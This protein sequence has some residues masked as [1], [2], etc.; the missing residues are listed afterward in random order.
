LKD[1]HSEKW[2]AVGATLLAFACGGSGGGGTGPCTPG[3]AT[4]LVK[5]GSDP[6]W[7]LNNPLPNPLGVT[8]KDANNCAVPGIVVNWSITTGGGGLG[9]TQSTTNSSG[10]ATIAD[11]VGSTSPQVVHAGSTG[12][13]SADFQVTA[14]APPT[15][16]G[17]AI[18]DFSFSPQAVVIKSGGT[19]TWTWGGAAPHNVTYDGGPAPLPGSSPTKTAT[20][21]FS[22]MITTVGQYTYHCSVHPTQM[23]GTVTVVH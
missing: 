21:T 5:N 6:S 22:S 20:G 4:Q 1:L 16:A 7:Y 19:V 12:L 3:L 8:V 9:S 10:I 23:T 18:A 13:P 17:V 2:L 14:S 15:T 11:S